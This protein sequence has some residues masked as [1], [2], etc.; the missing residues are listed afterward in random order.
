[1][2]KSYLEAF[3]SILSSCFTHTHTHIINNRAERTCKQMFQARSGYTQ[4]DTNFVQLH[5]VLYTCL[6]ICRSTW[7]TVILWFLIK[8]EVEEVLVLS[9]EEGDK[10]NTT[11]QYWRLSNLLVVHGWNPSP[12]TFLCLKQRCEAFVS[13]LIIS[14]LFF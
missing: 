7:Q 5:I 9:D 4:T 6:F 3:I 12:G 13:M 10:I 11:V 14:S 2:S 1:M 8:I